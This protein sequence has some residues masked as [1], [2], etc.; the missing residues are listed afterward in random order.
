MFRQGGTVILPQPVGDMDPAGLLPNRQLV[1]WPYTRLRDP[2]LLLDDDFILLNATPALPPCKIGYYNPHGFVGYWL[3]GVLFIKHAGPEREGQFPDG[4]CNTETY[5]NDKMVE[6]ETLGPLT[7]LT[8]GES[9]LHEE[10]WELYDNLDQ[11][12][13][14]ASLQ[15]RLS[16][17]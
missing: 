7:R 6:L 8:P 13:L 17:I 11:P 12:F 4:G 5:C 15:K 2:R 14:P 1:V 9:V 16:Q 3:N 10:T